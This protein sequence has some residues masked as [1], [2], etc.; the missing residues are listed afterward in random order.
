MSVASVCH[1]HGR[2]PEGQQF[3]EHCMP[4]GQ[5]GGSPGA[6]SLSA[7]ETESLGQFVAGD[8]TGLPRT[9]L[10]GFGFAARS[11]GDLEY[12]SGP[13]Q[14]GERW[15]L[16]LR[17][18]RLL[19]RAEVQVRV[20]GQSRSVSLVNGGEHIV[21]FEALIAGTHH[22]NFHVRTDTRKFEGDGSVEARVRGGQGDRPSVN[23]NASGTGNLVNVNVGSSENPVG[24]WL[25]CA[26]R[27]HP[28]AAVTLQPRKN[29]ECVPNV[30][31]LRPPS[32]QVCRLIRGNRNIIGR[33]PQSHIDLVQLGQPSAELSAGFSR[34]ALELELRSSGCV[35]LAVRNRLGAHINGQPLGK[36]Q[37]K[38]IPLHAFESSQ[39]IEFPGEIVVRLK[40]IP[41][42][43]EGGTV[44]SPWTEFGHIARDH[45][46]GGVHVRVEILGERIDLFWVLDA[47]SFRDVSPRLPGA[48]IV[49]EHGECLYH[50]D[51]TGLDPL[52]RTGPRSAFPLERGAEW[53]LPSGRWGVPYNADGEVHG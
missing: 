26:L 22:L 27:D 52:G 16:R 40:S 19:G 15:T 48:G 12:N 4:P 5:Q 1:V 8:S 32:G 24:S 46:V 9:A 23:V 42:P 3:C 53:D 37:S 39:K 41:S 30:V 28:H 49:F 34:E 43:S 21:Q 45:G 44:H 35:H 18:P 36:D 38:D 47:V 31:F 51:T 6:V 11:I 7:C 10:P 25:L 29:T 17:L 50:L 2:L 14:P 33:G 13:V 20:A